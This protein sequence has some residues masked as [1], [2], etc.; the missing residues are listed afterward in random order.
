MIKF[1]KLHFSTLFFVLFV[2]A[3]IQHV[4]RSSANDPQIQIAEDV[5]AALTSGLTP[6][7]IIGN[8]STNQ[9]LGIIQIV[10]IIIWLVGYYFEVVGDY[11]MKV[12]KSKAENKGPVSNL[13]TGRIHG[14]I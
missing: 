1:D 3:E 2:Y 11:Q 7:N 8:N 9:S 10:G 4:L 5:V 13:A 6:Q 12:F 14:Q